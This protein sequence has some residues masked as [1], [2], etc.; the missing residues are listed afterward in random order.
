MMPLAG[1]RPLSAP[2]L[3]ATLRI[4]LFVA[5]MLWGTVLCAQDPTAP[6]SAAP[7]PAQNRSVPPVYPLPAPDSQRV[8]SLAMYFIVLV[9]LAGVGLYLL[10]NGLPIRGLRAGDARKLQIVEMRALGNRQF[11]LVVEYE[12]NRMLLGVTS[13]RIDYLCPLDG[14]SGGR[15]EAPPEPV[16][17]S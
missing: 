1:S 2:W 8:A 12:Q 9:G 15:F 6:T 7:E 3:S 11:L 10:R 4:A 14:G 5:G 13:G 16:G 17:A